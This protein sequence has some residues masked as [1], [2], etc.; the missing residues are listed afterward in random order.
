MT[1]GSEAAETS[2]SAAAAQ[3]AATPEEQAAPVEKPVDLSHG[4]DATVEVS[5]VVPLPVDKVWSAL[6]TRQGAEALLG[7]GAALG[8]KG[9]PWRSEEGTHGVLRSFH[10]LEQIRLSWHADDDAPSSLVD[11]QL[12]PEGTSTRLDLSHQHVPDDHTADLQQR[13]SA[14]LDR[15][16]SA[17]A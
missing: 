11:L 6:I 2:E 17:S 8:G 12:H 15:L 10:P 5:T 3:G 14:A 9:E 13:W 16:V 4:H 7:S 1:A